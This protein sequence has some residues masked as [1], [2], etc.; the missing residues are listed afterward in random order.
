MSLGSWNV[1]GF[2]AVN[3]KSMIKDIVR[4]AK[5]DFIDLVETKH[6]EVKQWD[7]IKCW[8]RTKPNYTH[9][10][11]SN[12]SGGLMQLGAKMLLISITHLQQLAGCVWLM[13]PN[14]GL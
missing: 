13:G 8:G 2:G 11:A 14:C 12:N 10:A 9:V 6:S 7:L 4:L 5:L 3:K 1:R